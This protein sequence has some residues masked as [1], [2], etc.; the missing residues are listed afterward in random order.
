MEMK[1][2]LARAEPVSSD[3]EILAN[4]G[5]RMSFDA[6]YV[7][8]LNG[9]IALANDKQIPLLFS[10][11][12]EKVIGYA[13]KLIIDERGIVLKGKLTT[14]LDETNDIRV[15]F[16]AGQKW[17]ASLGF[18]V[19]ECESF[20]E[21][22]EVEVNG[23]IEEGPVCIA[24][25]IEIMECSIVS[26]GA[27]SKTEILKANDASKLL[28]A[29]ALVNVNINNNNELEEVAINATRKDTL[30]T[31]ELNM[32]NN[33]RI[34]SLAVLMQANAPINERNYKEAE[35]EAANQL[36]DLD[37]RSIVEAASG[38]NPTHSERSSA[39]EWLQA[40]A[41]SYGLNNIITTVSGEM[42]L[43]YMDSEKEPWR[44]IFKISSCSDQRPSYRYKIGSNGGYDLKKVQ[45]GAE[46][47]HA[48]Y[49][50]AKAV[51]S[52]DLYARQCVITE[53]ELLAGNAVGAL[54]DILRQSAAG[55]KQ[56]I[57][58]VLYKTFLNPVCQFDSTNFFDASRGNVFSSKA[59]T[60]ANLA[61]GVAK[62]YEC[63]QRGV[64]PR[65]LVVPSSLWAVAQTLCKATSM[66]T[67]AGSGADI[68]PIASAGLIPVAIP[69][70]E[71]AKYGGAYSSTTWYLMADPQELTAFEATFLNGNTT[72][73]MRRQ[74]VVVGFA[75]IKFDTSLI[76][77]CA[78]LDPQ[79]IVKFTA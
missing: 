25:A 16:E 56:C 48:V 54:A 51:I 34:A 50:D 73:R 30:M 47:E 49:D 32:N 46:F 38:W 33:T 77:G 64:D 17:Q 5:S 71:L 40:A 69:D 10:H 3:I 67:S 39:G 9:I 61:E 13:D 36:K 57:K 19:V 72:P 43:K 15:S 59:L 12:R 14:N 78:S 44:Q 45:A 24:K 23:R 29:S 28:E 52:A 41:S 76:F 27:D 55:A 8:D 11:N 74:D 1:E 26:L 60:Y 66:Y 37:F 65:Y 70:L 53:E 75:G 79:G 7:I 62:F 22:V 18:K 21:G 2:L 68:N 4:A 42:L 35:L 20:D 6:D 63:N 31:E 58:N